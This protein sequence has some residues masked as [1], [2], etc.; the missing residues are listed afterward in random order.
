MDCSFLIYTHAR[1][2]YNLTQTFHFLQAHEGDLLNRCEMILVCQDRMQFASDLPIRVVTLNDAVFNKPRMV[3]RSVR[4][5]TKSR[6]V[7]LDGDR[8]LPPHYFTRTLARL[9]R[10]EIVTTRPLYRLARTY[11]NFEIEEGRVERIRDWRDP[12]LVPGKKNAFSGNTTMWRDDFLAMGGMDE[13]YVNYGCADLDAST[14]AARNGL[15]ITYTDDE[16]LHLWHPF[17]MPQERFQAINAHSAV[18]YCLKW[19]RP[20]PDFF[21]GLLRDRP[22]HCLMP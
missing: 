7:M 3:N 11:S 17:D 20:V 22:H 2:L 21:L 10:G 5:A 14:A 19:G 16:E 1:R 12:D 18:K 6:I 13:T 4:E 9:E 15:K 8:I